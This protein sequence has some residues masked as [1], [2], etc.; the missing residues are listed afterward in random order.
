MNDARCIG[1]NIPLE[2]RRMLLVISPP[3]VRHCPITMDVDWIVML[4]RANTL[5]EGLYCLRNV[6]SD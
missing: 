4:L 2:K 3:E 5:S 6:S 1:T